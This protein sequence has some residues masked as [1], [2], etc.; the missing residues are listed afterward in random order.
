[1]LASP[2]PFETLFAQALWLAMFDPATMQ[3]IGSPPKEFEGRLDAPAI[4][5]S[6]SD[7]GVV[8]TVSI[9]VESRIASLMT[10]AVRR[11]TDQDQQRW[12][13]GDTFFRY[14]ASMAERLIVFPSAQAQGRR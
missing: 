6:P 4:G 3:L 2:Q 8:T 14:G 9:L 5:E 11:Y 10:A 7:S 13:P 12:H 1:V